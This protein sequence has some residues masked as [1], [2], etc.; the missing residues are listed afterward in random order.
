MQVCECETRP[1]CHGSGEE[2]GPVVGVD[3]ANLQKHAMLDGKI[4]RGSS[5][6]EREGGREVRTREG[7]FRG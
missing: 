6:R 2:L 1:A 4:C 3:E 5:G 7:Q